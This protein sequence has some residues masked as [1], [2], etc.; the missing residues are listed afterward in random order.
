MAGQY[1]VLKKAAD[2]L[3]DRAPRA[4]IG[5][6]LG[7]GL[8]EALDSLERP[9]FVGWDKIPGMP[10]PTTEGHR[11]SL[12]S[13]HFDDVP[14][15]AMCGRVHMYEDRPNEDVS[16][17]IR[18]LSLMGVHTL[19]VTSAVGS[20]DPQSPPGTFVLIEDHINLSGRNVL[21]GEHDPRFGPRFPDMSRNY[22][23]ELMTLFERSAE[24]VGV[25][26]TRGVLM[27]TL[28]PT[29][30]TPA[31]VRLA[32]SLGAKVV[33]MSMVPDVLTARQRGM[34]V[35]GIGCVTN[36]ASG[37]S[38]KPLGHEEVLVHSAALGAGLQSLLAG[39]LP[40]LAHTAN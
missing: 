12:L 9:R 33:S 5:V 14:V 21:S 26:L 7:S 10:R 27:H 16:A 32:A 19:V 38:E 30:E 36:M 40:T 13:G 25:P 34:R 37:L 23:P 11:G 20:V 6:V 2:G 8:S 24:Q 17:P 39:L 3:A 4:S 22:D 31:E 28:G 15:L 35:V 29:Y 1:D 18:L